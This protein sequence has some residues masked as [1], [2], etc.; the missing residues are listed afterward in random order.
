MGEK[1][2]IS[3]HVINM[4]SDS[5][6]IKYLLSLNSVFDISKS[7]VPNDKTS[8]K[9]SHILRPKIWCWNCWKSGFH[10]NKSAREYRKMVRRR[11]NK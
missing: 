5:T 2:K 11:K 9:K 6:K 3:R 4:T 10:L 7:R 8:T 1:Q